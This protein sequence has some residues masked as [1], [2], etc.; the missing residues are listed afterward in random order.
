MSG[1]LLELG[2]VGLGFGL[3]LKLNDCN[4]IG[5]K[6]I[7]SNENN[8]ILLYLERKFESWEACENFINMWVK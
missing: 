5:N 1:I 7:L 6:M 4:N 3:G 8:H 2:Y